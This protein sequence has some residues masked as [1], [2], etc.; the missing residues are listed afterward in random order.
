MSKKV[1]AALG[2]LALLASFAIVANADQITIGPSI[3]GNDLI[4]TDPKGAGPTT[5]GFTNNNT[6]SVT[7][8]G[9]ASYP[10]TTPF[11]GPYTFTFGSGTL[12]FLTEVSPSIYNVTMGTAPLTLDVCIISCANQLD[13]T[14]VISYLSDA[15]PALLN[16]SGT[17]TVTKVTGILYNDFAGGPGSLDFDVTLSRTVNSVDYVYGHRGKSTQGTISS[18]E[19]IGTPVPEPGTLAL[20]GSGLIGLA[21]I[22][23]RKSQAGESSRLW[24][25]K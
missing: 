9:T 12:P 21:G 15:N 4:V 1:I 19:V 25:T 6:P 14:V 11:S 23:R 3:K 10:D 5:I 18:G 7:L 17:I 13:G 24:Q 8:Q 2:C 22:L 20:L 16:I